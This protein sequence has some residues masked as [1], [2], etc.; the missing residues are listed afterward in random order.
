MKRRGVKIIVMRLK[1]GIFRS[2]EGNL[3]IFQKELGW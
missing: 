3:G 2:N 1:L